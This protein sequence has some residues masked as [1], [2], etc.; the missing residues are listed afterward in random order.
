MPLNLDNSPAPPM[1]SRSVDAAHEA[2]AA[3]SLLAKFLMPILRENRARGNDPA[4]VFVSG[5]ISD[6][7]ALR[8]VLQVMVNES[9]EAQGRAA[10]RG[11]GRV[12]IKA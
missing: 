5:L 7:G 1:S 3:C 12:K 8:G 6:L 2:L 4:A 9:N 10:Q 11:N